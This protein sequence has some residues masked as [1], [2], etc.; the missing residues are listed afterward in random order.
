MLLAKDLIDYVIAEVPRNT[1][2]QQHPMVNE[3]FNPAFPLSFL[4]RPGPQPR[5]TSN[6]TTLTAS[7]AD[8]APYVRVE[9]VDPRTE[10]KAMR[11][12]PKESRP[13]ALGAMPAGD[14]ELRLFDADNKVSDGAPEFKSGTEQF[15]SGHRYADS[16]ESHLCCVNRIHAGLI[17]ATRAS[18]RSI[19]RD[20]ARCRY[21]YLCGWG[22][23]ETAR[24]RSWN[25]A[26]F[27]PARTI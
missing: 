12:L 2:N 9:W 10:T 24:S 8:R 6:I 25:C 26:D 13:V 19:S 15:G 7:N 20:A 3:G 16:I 5:V 22:F 18:R 14:L 23:L 4:D 27:R 1:A 21:R 11:P 17:S